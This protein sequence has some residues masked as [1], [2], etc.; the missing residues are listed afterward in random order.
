PFAGRSETAIVFAQLE[1]PPPTLP[2][3]E[4]VFAKALAKEPD[5]RY[6]SG[7]ELIAAAR[8]AV[9]R[10]RR[11]RRRLLATFAVLAAAAAAIAVTTTRGHRGGA[12]A[13]TLAVEPNAV[14]V[15]DQR[16]PRVGATVGRTG[17]ASD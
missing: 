10:T 15:V 16:S 9:A 14:S 2:L 17:A 3:F 11:P 5:D 8:T 6:E 1:E 4:E 12:A 7:R 13:P